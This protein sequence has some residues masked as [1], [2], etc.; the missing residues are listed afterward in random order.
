MSI[1]GTRSGIAITLRPV[2]IP[3]RSVTVD[4]SRPGPIPTDL[5]LHGLAAVGRQVAAVTHD[6]NNLMTIVGGGIESLLEQFER[7]DSRR[8]V[9]EM[10]DHATSQ[11]K[12]ISR[13]LLDLARIDASPRPSCEQT[14]DL[15]AIV[16]SH[17]AVL[18]GLIGSDRSLVLGLTDHPAEITADPVRIG[19]VI[20]NLAANARDAMPEGGTLA[21]EVQ[22]QTRT[23]S[24]VEIPGPLAVLTVS[25]TGVGMDTETLGRAFDHFYTTK[26]PGQGTGIGLPIVAEIVAAAGGVIVPESAPGTGTTIRV[27]FPLLGPL[28]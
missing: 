6:F 10:V 28:D 12:A 25:D 13:N 19:Q 3:A 21:I 23:E 8:A 24:G 17:A 5:N 16:A 20:L 26:P 7:D 1:A 2:G 14:C 22:I 4:P 18:E 27:Y 11:A 9:L 15:S